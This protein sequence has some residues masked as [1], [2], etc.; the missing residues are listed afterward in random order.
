MIHILLTYLLCDGNYF[1]HGCVKIIVKDSSNWHQSKLPN[2]L[3]IPASSKQSRDEFPLFHSAPAFALSLSHA[4][5]HSTAWRASFPKTIA[6]VTN[7]LARPPAYFHIGLLGRALSIASQIGLFVARDSWLCTHSQL[8]LSPCFADCIGSR[9]QPRT[10]WRE[11]MWG[12][13]CC[14][15]LSRA[16]AFSPIARARKGLF[17]RW[18]VV[19]GE[20][21]LDDCCLT[22]DD[23]VLKNI[24]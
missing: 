1:L 7:T 11:W 14:S 13:G 6:A 12:T 22:A 17:E 20:C 23:L 16:F 3:N 8:E 18:L 21:A 10:R 2:L 19:L 4:I 15:F 24:F 5:L 9:A